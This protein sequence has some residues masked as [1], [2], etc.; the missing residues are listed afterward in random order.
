MIAN[1]AIAQG[2]ELPNPAYTGINS[3]QGRDPVLMMYN[4]SQGQSK[5]PKSLIMTDSTHANSQSDAANGFNSL[6]Q[7]RLRS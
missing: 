3:P 7:K 1:K 2:N 4:P 6:A 5:N